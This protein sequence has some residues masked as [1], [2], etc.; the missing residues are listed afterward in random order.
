MS[1]DKSLLFNKILLFIHQKPL[2]LL[3]DVCQELRISRGTLEKAIYMAT[4][5]TFRRFREEV[6]LESA[7]T[8]LSSRPT[9]SI[10]EISVDL[11]FKSARSFARAI[12]RICGFS[13]EQLRADTSQTRTGRSGFRAPLPIVSLINLKAKSA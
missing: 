10:K 9:S 4:G 5:K 13:P 8:L 1:Y 2:S 12:K 3:S 6:L 7:T 11:G